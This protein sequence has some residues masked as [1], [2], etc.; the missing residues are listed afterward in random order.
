ICER[1]GPTGY[2]SGLTLGERLLVRPERPDAVFCTTDLI[3]CGVMD[4]ARHRFS[5]SIPRDLSVI[6]FDDIPQAGWDAYQ[7]TTFGQPIHGI[8]SAAIDW[9]ADGERGDEPRI[10]HLTAPMAWRKSVR[11]GNG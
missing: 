3:A 10:V 7:L 6:G 11:G 4:A 8:A 2:E 9:L 5:L 1:F